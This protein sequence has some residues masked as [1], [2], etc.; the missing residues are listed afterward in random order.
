MKIKIATMNVENL[1][2]RFDFAA[3]ANPRDLQYLPPAAAFFA[4][5]ANGD[6]TRFGEFKALVQAAT[7]A[8]DDDKR[9]HTA[10]VL[11]EANADIVCLQEI[12]DIHA[13]QR[14]RD[15]YLGKTRDR[16]YDQLIVH[17]GNDLRGIDVAAMS[18]RALPLLSR[19]HAWM[20][21][22][23][24]GDRPE[25][26][27][28]AARYPLIKK[29]LLPEA[30]GDS[31][32]QR[33]KKLAATIFKRDCLELELRR[34]GRTLSIFVCHLKSMSGGDER[35][36]TVDERQLEALA[37]RAIIKARFTQPETANWLVVG[38]MNDYRRY[39]TVAPEPG[40]DGLFREEVMELTNEPAE[41]DRHSGLDPLLDDGFAVDLVARRAPADQWT[42]YFAPKRAKSQ[43]D[44]ILASPALAQRSPGVPR[45]IRSGQPYR[46]PNTASVP[47]FPRIGWDRPKASDHCAVVAEIDLGPALDG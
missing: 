8:L 3:F 39:V 41:A 32:E 26:E 37:V 14:F 11:N 44:H 43:L 13:L 7:V 9:Q 2:T 30:L 18:S 40:E 10:L 36:D 23:D 16:P 28:L 45:I 35:T 19:S 27:A 31:E 12:D 6:L 21:V 17:E 1:F 47:R 38:D 42:H 29:K 4:S 20:G 5:Q 24:L 33:R 34:A 46:V 15:L 25:R 22:G